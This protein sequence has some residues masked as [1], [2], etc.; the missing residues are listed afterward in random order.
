MRG[1]RI[2]AGLGLA[3]AVFVGVEAPARPAAAADDPAWKARVEAAITDLETKVAAL[4]GKAAAAGTPEARVAALHA[5]LVAVEQALGRAPGT[6]SGKPDLA[7]LTGDVGTLTSRWRAATDA[8]AGKPAPP[9]PAP[10][11]PPTPKPKP[12][13]AVPEWPKALTFAV[14]ASLPWKE[15]GEYRKIEVDKDVW[16]ERFFADGF[17]ATLSLT[18]SARGLVRDV[19]SAEL[20]VA[21]RLEPPLSKREG[22]WRT[23][24]YTWA[25]ERG[26]GNGSLRRLPAHDRFAL[27]QPLTV[28]RARRSASI[29]PEAVAHV[30]SVTLLDGTTKTFDV[31]KYGPGADDATPR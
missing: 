21:V 10:P 17:E 27:D 14:N 13:S 30:V 18:M 12:A 28:R 11:T 3:A 20:L 24:P 5:R 23:Y 1:V 6:V 29:V 22:E 4:D 19:R 2:G 31:P 25:G 8:K 26:F 9:P 16:E 7:S 15:T